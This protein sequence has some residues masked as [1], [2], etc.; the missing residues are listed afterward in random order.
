MNREIPNTNEIVSYIHC[1]LCARE[2]PEGIAPREWKD[3]EVGWTKLGLQ[4]WCVR[5]DVNV[6]HIDF[7]GMKH[8]ANITRKRTR[9]E[10]ISN[11]FLDAFEDDE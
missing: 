4:V 8:P 6:I 9:D 1:G 11:T 10:D 2:L 3:L 7:E 5:H